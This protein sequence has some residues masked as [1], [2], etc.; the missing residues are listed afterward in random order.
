MKKAPLFLCG[1]AL[2][3]LLALG[4]LLVPDRSFSPME[5]RLLTAAPAFSPAALLDGKWTDGLESYLQD[6]LPL[7]DGL[8]SL[9]TG[10]EALRG[11]RA[12][13]DVILGR[14]NRLL[15]RTD[16]WSERSVAANAK[17][18]ASLS[19]QSGVPVYLLAVPSAAR[20]YPEALPARA[21]MADEDALLD[22]A[23][24][25]TALLPLVQEME[26]VKDAAPLYYRTDHH[27]TAAGA[28]AGYLC[29]CRA[30]GLEPLEEEA[31][32]PY[33][34]FFGSFYARCPLP[35]F[36]ADSFDLPSTAGITLR[37]DG[38][39]KP[40]CVDAEVLAGRD[41]YAALFYGNH[42]LMT[43]ENPSAPEGT[44]FVLKDSYANAL[45][46]ALCRHYRRIVAADGRYFS[47]NIVDAVKESKGEA[48]LCV[49]GLS[50]LST[51]R[52]IKLLEG[53]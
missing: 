39:E 50:T 45:L 22:I 20:I 10:W 17:A 52:S 4:G 48:V 1:M 11:Q 21:P 13:N 2:F 29:A 47:G 6:Q 42:P 12:L 36:P 51:G 16:G 23:A 38:E 18:L 30:L 5:N 26:K 40:G 9:Y 8:V 33:P 44:L 15:D 37:V 28:R 24:R 41:K 49:Y 35:F 32:T 34:G 7:R 25:E 3:L 43:L 14:E 19:E 53:L 27:W 31:P 46:P